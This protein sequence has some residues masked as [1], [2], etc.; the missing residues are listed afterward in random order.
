MLDLH[1][2]SSVAL[3][4][5]T[6]SVVGGSFTVW[7]AIFSVLEPLSNVAQDLKDHKVFECHC[8]CDCGAEIIPWRLLGIVAV[9]FWTVGCCGGFCCARR[10]SLVVGTPVAPTTAAPVPIIGPPIPRSLGRSALARR[11]Q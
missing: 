10:Q 11:T 3:A 9:V 5:V 7:R 2:F 4:A 8:D 1:P 6:T